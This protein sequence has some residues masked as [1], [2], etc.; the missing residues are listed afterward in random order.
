MGA[1]AIGDDG[2][3][4]GDGCAEEFEV[5]TAR[6]LAPSFSSLEAAVFATTMASESCCESSWDAAISIALTCAVIVSFLASKQS[7]IIAELTLME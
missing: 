7:A 3:E 2:D 5:G 1:D 4:N 6:Y